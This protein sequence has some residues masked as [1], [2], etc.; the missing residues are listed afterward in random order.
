MELHEE[1][2]MQTL[3]STHAEPGD[4]PTFEWAGPSSDIPVLRLGGGDI[5]LT[6]LQADL[7]AFLL[8]LSDAAA[9]FAAAVAADGTRNILAE[10]AS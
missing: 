7:G 4:V 1:Y 8:A 2:R 3:T 10:A 6:Q 9:E 5:H